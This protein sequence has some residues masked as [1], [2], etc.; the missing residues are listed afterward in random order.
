[1]LH[2]PDAK[3]RATAP[4]VRVQRVDGEKGVVLPP[5]SVVTPYCLYLSDGYLGYLW[6]KSAGGFSKY[7]CPK[8]A[9]E[10][11]NSGGDLFCIITNGQNGVVIPKDAKPACAN[12]ATKR[13]FGYTYA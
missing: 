3:R 2:P 9:R 8:S 11:S 1:M 13:R 10:S 7:P 4:R 6:P 12:I 5:S